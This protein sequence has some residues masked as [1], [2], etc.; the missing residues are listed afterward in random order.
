MHVCAYTIQVQSFDALMLVFI[1]EGH[2]VMDDM[3]DKIQKM[4]REILWE[5]F[6][7]S[8]ISGEIVRSSE[9]ICVYPN[10]VDYNPNVLYFII[11][12]Y[13]FQ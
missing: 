3:E 12:V 9:M 1:K 7:T 8:C 2:F 11:L 10:S 5:K 4:A 6:G 13:L